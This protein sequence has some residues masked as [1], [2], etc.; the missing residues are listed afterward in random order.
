M[1][2]DTCG[3]NEP[4]TEIK[5]DVGCKRSSRLTNRCCHAPLLMV[6]QRK[7]SDI[8]SSSFPEHFF[9]L[10]DLPPSPG[11]APGSLPCPC[12]VQICWLVLMLKYDW[13]Y[14]CNLPFSDTCLQCLITEQSLYFVLGLLS[15]QNRREKHLEVRGFLGPSN[16]PSHKLSPPSLFPLTAT[17]QPHPW[18][19]G[20]LAEHLSTF[21]N[22]RLEILHSLCGASLPCSTAL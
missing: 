16:I 14:D 13:V 5:H 10:W 1:L 18:G 19:G 9:L 20:I 4:V 21:S 2:N 7:V 8:S 22:L 11:A 3:L 17:L 6:I 12:S 15:E